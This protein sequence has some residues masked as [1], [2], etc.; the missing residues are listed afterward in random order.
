MLGVTTLYHETLFIERPLANF[1]AG[2]LAR[3][4]SGGYA[5]WLV[6][7]GAPAPS[8]DIGDCVGHFFLYTVRKIFAL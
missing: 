6:L 4:R 5:G 2:L 1:G 3:A 7:A 8:A